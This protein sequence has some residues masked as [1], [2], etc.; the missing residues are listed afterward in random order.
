MKTFSYTHSGSREINQDSLISKPI[1]TDAVLHLV[2]DGIG[3][4]QFGEIASKSVAD[5][6]FYALTLNFDLDNAISYASQKLNDERINLG[7]QK[8]G[9]TVAGVILRNNHAEIFWAGDSRVFIIRKDKIIYQT[10]D[11]SLVNQMEKVRKLSFDEKKRFGHIITRSIM[12]S[13]EDF[14]EKHTVELQDEDEILICTDGLYNECPIDYVIETI[15][16]DSFDIP[17]TSSEFADNHSLIYI[18]YSPNE[19]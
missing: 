6:I 4:C 5:N 17:A 10:L 3:G 12:G 8:M 2:A 16:K 15:R 7:A 13:S 9:T 1:S 19:N 18:K 11:H 14:V